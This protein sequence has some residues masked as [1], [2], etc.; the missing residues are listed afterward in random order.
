MVKQDTNKKDERFRPCEYT[1]KAT[2]LGIPSIF[3]NSKISIEDVRR[4]MLL[5]EPEDKIEFQILSKKIGLDIVD[6]KFFSTKE[7]ILMIDF[8]IRTEMVKFN[9]RRVK[10]SYF[11]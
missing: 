10:F 9:K 7:L 6:K 1:I 5:D 4:I 3:M 8:A 11:Q 2:A